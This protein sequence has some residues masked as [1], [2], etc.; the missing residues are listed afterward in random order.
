[1]TDRPASC[2]ALPLRIDRNGQ[3][4]CVE[5]A[6][7]LTTLFV[8]MAKTDAGGWPHAPWFAL[9]PVLLR[10]EQ[11]KDDQDGVASALNSALRAL[12]VEGARVASVKTGIVEDHGTRAFDLAIEID[13]QSVVHTR[14]EA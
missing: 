11:R 2:L 14:L 3:F 9:Q 4:E 7:S 5:L 8:A 1:M 10:A 13:G 12:R 6:T